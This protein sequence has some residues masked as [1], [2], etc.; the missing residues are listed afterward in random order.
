[1]ALVNALTVSC[2][3]KL[4]VVQLRMIVISQKFV[5][6]DLDIVLQIHLS[7]MEP[8]VQAAHQQV[9][10]AIKRIHVM[11]MEY[12][13]ITFTQVLSFAVLAKES[14]MSLKSAMAK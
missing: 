13:W 9:V 1:M 2:L 10:Y 6:V 12:A 3:V 11:V 5:V 4:S 14:V 7:Q 8:H